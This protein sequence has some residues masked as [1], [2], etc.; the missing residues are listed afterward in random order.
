[1]ARW[2]LTAKERLMAKVQEDPSG[3]WIWNGAKRSKRQD[4]PDGY[5]AMWFCGAMRPAHV[6]AYILFVDAEL[7]GLKVLHRCDTPLCVRPEHLFLGTDS[8]NMLDCSAKG[9]HHMS[10]RS[11]CKNGH[12]LSLARVVK[13]GRYQMRICRQCARDAYR[14][15]LFSPL[16]ETKA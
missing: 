2:T 6:V 3:C 15:R 4:R 14:R 10:S 12:D 9:R 5:G 8:D 7:H 16:P 11:T 13:N 1:M